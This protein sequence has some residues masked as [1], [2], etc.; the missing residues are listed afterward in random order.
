MTLASV[1]LIQL[2]LELEDHL[3]TAQTVLG[4]L[5][6][7]LYIAYCCAPLSSTK[8][9]L[10]TRSTQGLP[11][12]LILATVCATALWTCYGALIEDYVVII[13]NLLGFLLSTAQLS[14]FALYPSH[15]L[16]KHVV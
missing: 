16:I 8:Q 13:P 6:S 10:M 7:L 14:L 9:V 3:E 1:V 4:V 5:C 12:I 15:P 2:Y 11:F